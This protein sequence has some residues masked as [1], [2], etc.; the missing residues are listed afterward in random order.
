MSEHIPT[1]ELTLVTGA[2]G[3][4]GQ[5]VVKALRDQGTPVKAAV[6]PGVSPK[7]AEL[8]KEWGA[9]V[10][11]L[12]LLN[13][14]QVQ[15]EVEDVTYV[16]HLVGSINKPQNEDFMTMHEGRTRSLIKAL[17]QTKPKKIIFVSALGASFRSD[18][19][20]QVSKWEA[21][22]VIRKS[23]LPYVILRSSLVIGHEAGTRDSKLI[24]KM[25]DT[26]DN[27]SFI[28]VISRVDGKLQPVFIGDLTRLVCE[29][30]SHE[31]LQ[32][33]TIEVGGPDQVTPFD[34]M[35][36]IAEVKGIKKQRKVIPFF[37]VHLGV[38]LMEKFSSTPKM[39]LEQLNMMRFD[40][41]VRFPNME[42]YFDFKLKTIREALGYL[43][44]PS[45]A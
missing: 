37:F 39:T 26:V 12:D 3:Y 27:S 38:S 18:S 11:E 5:H 36:I 10:V 20:Y 22:E 21:E 31:Q 13:H 34:L 14:A 9:E 35:E 23:F 41:I 17:Q 40:N 8:L 1:T 25:S 15:K 24:T 6:R 42:N 16:V 7:E 43:K 44:E 4:I 30:L 2:N 28:P 33:Q 19:Q 45:K 32:R 29:S